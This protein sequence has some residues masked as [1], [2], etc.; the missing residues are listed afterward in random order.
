[1]RTSLSYHEDV[2]SVVTTDTE[3]FFLPPPAFFSN[4]TCCR[5]IYIKVTL[6]SSTVLLTQI[7]IYNAPNLMKTVTNMTEP[8][9]LIITLNV[10][11]LNASV[12]DK[13]S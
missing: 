5:I 10:H 3:G 4:G 6:K 9:V 13:L 7:P 1:M 11:G 8:P 12:K 2:P